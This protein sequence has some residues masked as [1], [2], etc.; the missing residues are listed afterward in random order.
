VPQ[1]R[2]EISDDQLGEFGSGIVDM[3]EVPSQG[4]APSRPDK[5][6]GVTQKREGWLQLAAQGGG[7]G[8]VVLG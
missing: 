2:L 7:T 8:A 3:L 4:P 1:P 6:V 5:L